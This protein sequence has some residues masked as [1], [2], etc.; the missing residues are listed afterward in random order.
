M[1][2]HPQNSD[3]TIVLKRVIL[4]KMRPDIPQNGFNTMVSKMTSLLE[5]KPDLPQNGVNTMVARKAF[6]ITMPDLPQN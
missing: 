2:S 4:Y 6:P 5:I 1:K 3:K